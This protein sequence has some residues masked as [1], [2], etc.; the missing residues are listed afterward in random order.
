MIAARL[1]PFLLG[2]I[3]WPS[4]LGL[5]YL[6]TWL[7][8][9]I[10]A[11]GGRSEIAFFAILT[12]ILVCIGSLIVWWKLKWSILDSAVSLIPMEVLLWLGTA[13]IMECGATIDCLIHLNW[14]KSLFQGYVIFY[15]FN[16]STFVIIPWSAGLIL[17]MLLTRKSRI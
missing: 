6:I 4:C 10:R 1:K 8:V 17:G 9:V 13:W 14:V 3:I 12:A 16:I 5:S 2:F 11:R 15:F 7:H